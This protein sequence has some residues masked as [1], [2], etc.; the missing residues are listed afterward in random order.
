M[1]LSKSQYFNFGCYG[2]QAHLFLSHETNQT[3]LIKNELLCSQIEGPYNLHPDLFWAGDR[4]CGM[5]PTVDHCW[6]WPC[7]EVF[8]LPISPRLTLQKLVT[9]RICQSRCNAKS[10]NRG[11]AIVEFS[12]RGRMSLPWI[13][14]QA[15][16]K[17]IHSLPRVWNLVSDLRHF[18]CF[19][20]RTGPPRLPVGCSKC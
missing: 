7:K 11:W 18:R 14:H 10:V 19:P 2:S 6:P 15:S 16:E 13:T 12:F 17:H 9:H 3:R 4:G 8:I 20:S 5:G 1:Q